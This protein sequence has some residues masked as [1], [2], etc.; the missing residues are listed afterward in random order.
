[1]PDE[2]VTAIDLATGTVAWQQKYPTPFAKN[3][4][5]TSMAKG[6]HATP[7]VVGDTLVTVGGT[8]VVTGWHARTGAK[9]WRI[10][11][12]PSFDTSKLFTGTAASPLAEGGSV[13]VQIGS[14]VHGGGVVGLDPKTGKEHAPGEGEAPAPP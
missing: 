4:Y 14:D 12:S 2:I 8:D 5:A 1:D 7:L 9:L 3:Q 10:V 6:P 13:V 11:Y